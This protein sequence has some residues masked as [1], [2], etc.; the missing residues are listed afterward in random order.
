MPLSE[1]AARASALAGRLRARLAPWVAKVWPERAWS[2]PH[3]ASV[4]G[5]I[6]CA[7][8][9]AASGAVGVQARLDELAAA[10]G[11]APVLQPVA[12][13]SPADVTDFVLTPEALNALTE[14]EARAWNA[15]LPVSTLPLLAARPFIMD[16]TDWESYSRALDCL[17]AA[18]HYEA[19]NEPAVG[20]A[21]VAQ[22]VLNRVRHPAYPSTVC[23]VVF[24][25][26]ERE[27]GCQFTFTCDGSLAR[28]PRPEAWA[29]ARA[30]A[31]AALNGLVIPNVG[32]ATH[33]HA[34]YVAPIWATNLVKLGQI[35]VH[36]FYRWTGAWG[37]P[38]AFNVAHPGTEPLL[39]DMAPIL[40]LTPTP[41]VEPV[42]MLIEVAEVEPLR[43]AA[44]EA[45]AAPVLVTAVAPPPPVA[46]VAE[47]VRAAAPAPAAPVLADPL[48]R[49]EAQA[50]RRRPRIAAPSSW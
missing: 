42:P 8:I 24:Q 7:A 14:D 13:T 36:I 22:V 28:P 9:L 1:I 37:L 3:T 46:P 15:A 30:V 39:P 32:M 17:T 2:S 12:A 35:G 6:S 10:R 50:E 43:P 48:A 27:T 34:D 4:T 26:S 44:P 41:E 38:G 31:S 19:A 23:G 20:Q 5:W 47:P 45:A 18:V 29:R 49:P 16:T 11:P 21:A 33:Y 40:T 25:G